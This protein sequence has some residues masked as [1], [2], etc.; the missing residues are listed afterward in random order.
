MTS[1]HD[2]I[3]AMSFEQAMAELE[4]IVARLESGEEKLDDAIGA[5]ERGAALKRHCE[6]RLREAQDKVERI[7]LDADGGVTVEAAD[8]A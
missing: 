3:A 1:A 6:A 2:D 4:A 8:I 7:R 5:Y